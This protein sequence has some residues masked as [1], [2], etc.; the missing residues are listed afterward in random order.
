MNQT[1]AAHGA[2]NSLKDLIGGLSP[3]RAEAVN[4]RVRDRIRLVRQ[5]SERA[6]AERPPVGELK[7]DLIVAAGES[8]EQYPRFPDCFG[9]LGLLN[10]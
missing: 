3:G 4:N 8:V 2:K 6:S 7:P 1:N 9:F 5:F 10:Q